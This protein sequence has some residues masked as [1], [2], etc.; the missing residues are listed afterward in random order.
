MVAKRDIRAG[1]EV[2]DFYGEHFFLAPRQERWHRLG[3]QC[4][5]RPCR[6]GKGTDNP[7]TQAGEVVQ[8]G[9]PVPVPPMQV[10]LGYFFLASRQQRWHSL[11]FQCQCR[12][13]RYG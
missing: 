7:G 3:F 1:E 13:C 2:T 8:A 11:G 12:P 4:Q 9:L 6:Y 5:C 10:R